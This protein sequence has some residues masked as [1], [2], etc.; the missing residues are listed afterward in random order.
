MVNPGFDFS[1]DQRIIF[2][3]GKVA[4]LGKLAAGFGRRALLI[5]N[6]EHAD[7]VRI[8]KLLDLASLK[9]SEVEIRSEPTLMDVVAA[10]EVGKQTDCELVIGFGGGS[11]IDTAKAV[12]ALLT[13]LG[14]PLDYLEVVGKGKPITEQ[15]KPV[16]AIPTSAGTGSEVTR[17]AVLAV[18]EKH[19]KVSLR[20]ALMLPSVALVD[21]ELTLSLPPTFTAYTG[22]DALTQVLE[23]YVSIRANGMTDLFCQAGLARVGKALPLAFDHPD[24][25]DARQDMSFVSLM[26]GL[27]LAN[28]GL[29]AVHGLAGPIGGMFPSAHGAICARLLPAVVKVNIQA[30]S[31]RKGNDSEALIRYQQAAQY[32]LA[33]EKAKAAD[34]SEW[35]E[36]LVEYLHIPGL[37]EFGIQPHH[38]DE[39]AKKAQGASSMQANP[40]QL[41][42]AELLEILNASL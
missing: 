3:I 4:E 15:P 23:P 19:I 33:S 36:D 39:I 31:S 1:T 24:E 34:L 26:G 42:L 21:P 41:E 20:S 30:L 32:L 18:P 12:A 10:I 9:Y 11:A 7:T 8:R 6:G 25:I 17:N 38:L 5:R 16:V 29:G 2:G 35:L 28:S 14:D 27:A 22:M 13:N 40:I 37:K